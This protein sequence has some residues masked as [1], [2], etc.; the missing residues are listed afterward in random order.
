MKEKYFTKDTL[1]G[2]GREMLGLAQIRK[3]RGMARFNQDEIALFV[4]DMQNYFF[5]SQSHAFVPSGPA[6]VPG[7]TTLIEAFYAKGQPVI[8]TQHINT[9]DDAGMMKYW[10]RDLLTEDHPDVNLIPQ[11]NTS[12]GL[13]VQKTQYDAF[14]GTELDE[15]LR[16]KDISQV[17]VCGVMSHLCCETTARAAFVRDFE[18]YF[19]VDGT[20]TYSEL[21]HLA[22]LRNL[23]HGFATLVTL[24]DVLDRFGEID[25]S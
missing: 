16:Q 9:K 17:V 10:W 11:L 3:P 25:A 6:I 8:F 5:N 19:T 23:S 2:K 7:V 4:L 18:V 14:Y 1:E 21:H 15:I 12:S 24:Q 13:L 20:A 22:T